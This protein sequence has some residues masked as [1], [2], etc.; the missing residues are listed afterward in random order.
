MRMPRLKTESGRL[1]TIPLPLLA[2]Q[3]AIVEKVEKLLNW[4][5]ELDAKI[6]ESDRLN[7][8]LM[9]TVVKEYT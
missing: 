3:K 2:E 6:V 5:D 8:L 9:Q 7:G 4:C 1:A